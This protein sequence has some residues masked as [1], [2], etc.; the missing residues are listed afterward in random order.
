MKALIENLSQVK[1]QGKKIVILG[2]MLEM[3]ERANELHSELG[4]FVGHKNFDVVWFLG[5]FS[6]SFEEGMKRARFQKKLFISNG[7][8]ESLA[9]KVSSMIEPSDIVVMKVSRGAKLEK[10]VPHFKPINWGP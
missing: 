2:D 1:I 9:V 6:K 10:L 8:E 7:Y 3:G 4:E 5:Q